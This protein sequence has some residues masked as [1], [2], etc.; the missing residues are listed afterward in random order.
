MLV[1]QWIPR[2][3]LGHDV[4]QLSNTIA[5]SYQQILSPLH[6]FFLF[7]DTGIQIMLDLNG[8][9]E[10]LFALLKEIIGGFES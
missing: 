9:F 4:L 1:S 8:I 7:L 10:L 3:F 5:S 6:D 2:R